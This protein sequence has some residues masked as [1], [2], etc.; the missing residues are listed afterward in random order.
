[1]PYEF[2]M[3]GVQKKCSTRGC[4]AHLLLKPK[5]K[6]SW[7]QTESWMERHSRLQQGF[8]QTDG[9]TW[10]LRG[11]LCPH[12]SLHACTAAIASF[13]SKCVFQVL[14]MF[15]FSSAW[16]DN[17]PSW[18]LG[19]RLDAPRTPKELVKMFVSANTD[20]SGCR[21]EYRTGRKFSF[22]HWRPEV[23]LQK[24]RQRIRNHLHFFSILLFKISIN[25]KH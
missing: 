5:S 9:H 3:T 16:K 1:M 14:N 10:S 4:C 13:L 6:R 8:H 12:N 7:W 21:K 24:N 18:T 23:F 25:S 15:C 17:S 11:L 22:I 2:E 19:G 20:I